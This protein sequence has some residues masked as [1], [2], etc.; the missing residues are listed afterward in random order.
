VLIGVQ[1]MASK[2]GGQSGMSSVADLSK[3]IKSSTSTLSGLDF[4]RGFR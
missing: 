3:T 1:S 2:E 4:R